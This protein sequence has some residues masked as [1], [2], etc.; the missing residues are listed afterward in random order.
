MDEVAL[1]N[2]AVG[3]IFSLTW[4]LIS[5]FFA[6]YWKF[7][8]IHKAPVKIPPRTTLFVFLMFVLLQIVIIPLLFSLLLKQYG[9]YAYASMELQG[10]LN[11]GVITVIALWLIWV[12]KKYWHALKPLFNPSHL[13]KDLTLGFSSWLLGFPLILTASQILTFFL[14]DLFNFSLEEQVAVKQIKSILNNPLLFTFSTFSVVVLAPFIEEVL[15]RGFLQ[16]TLLH[17]FSQKKAIVL[18]SL[19][20][21]LFHFSASQG[22]NN[23]N[24]LLSLFLLA[25]ILGLLKEKQG[26]LYP[27]MALHSL[28][29][30]VSVLLLIP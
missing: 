10:W 6:K 28:F 3:F 1:F 7:F 16:S 29:N 26:T 8:S 2:Q 11:L 17:F 21:A 15:F 24:I 23:L 4:L 22:I 18:S 19:I 5:L 27:S 20:F 9:V 25:L 30:G 14:V 12:I 13:E